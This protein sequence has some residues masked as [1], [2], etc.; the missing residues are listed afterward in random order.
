MGAA[1]QRQRHWKVALCVLFVAIA[2]GLFNVGHA[3][4]GF[5]PKHIAVGYE[6]ASAGAL[7]ENGLVEQVPGFYS[8]V[9]IVFAVLDVRPLLA[10]HFPFQLV[11]HVAGVFTLVYLLSDRNAVVAGLVAGLQLLITTSATTRIYLWPHGI[12]FIVF[13]TVSSALVLLFRK[14]VAAR[15]FLPV[16]LCSV[17]L[18]YVSYNLTLIHLFV[19]G[20]TF[21][22]L[23][24]HHLGLH[25]YVDVVRPASSPA[26]RTVLL[27][28]AV[29]TGTLALSSE[30]FRTTTQRILQQGFDIGVFWQFLS[31]WVG[32]SEGGGTSE[33]AHLTTA[34]PDAVRYIAM[35][36]YGLV[37]LGILAFTAFV[38]Y[39]LRRGEQVV[40]ADLLL[41][42]Y[43]AGVALY[44]LAR[45]YV[46]SVAVGLFYVPG[47]LSMAYLHAA[48]DERRVAVTAAVLLVL[49]AG[50][51]VGTQ[52]V[53][54]Q[55]DGI[56]RNLVT[57]YETENER[58]WLES[59]SEADRSVLAP[60]FDRNVLTYSSMLAQPDPVYRQASERFGLM[61]VSHAAAVTTYEDPPGESY[62]LLNTREESMSLQSWRIIESWAH[63]REAIHANPYAD[64]VYTDGETWIL[65]G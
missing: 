22:L 27:V 53:Y 64:K 49:V 25:R 54:N 51:V 21:A 41:C 42:S 28:S 3:V 38:L 10:L 2:A 52:V 31:V 1:L 5:V 47:M 35:F 61:G 18:V 60:E 45:I 15:V 44:F 65:A 46:G 63:R 33:I 11:P 36:R 19:L 50:S 8:L 26:T 12:G 16:M 6:A 24:A 58:A 39:K 20:A 32:G 30:F 17:A 4:D 14:R 13:F 29:L 37:V 55:Q 43:L 59:Y 40:S 23:E 34:P 9:A 48:A 62:L 7:P 57:A 56:D